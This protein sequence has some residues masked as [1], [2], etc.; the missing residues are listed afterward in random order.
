MWSGCARRRGDRHPVYQPRAL[1]RHVH[2]GSSGEWSPFFTF[3]VERNRVLV[4]I[5]NADW[6]LAVWTL[7]GFVAR[8]GRSGWRWARS[9][10]AGSAGGRFRA[11][12]GAMLSL[13]RHAPAALLDRYSRRRGWL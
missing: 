5:K 3:H 12:V 7:L 6:F 11:S 1:L 8:V 9:G 2:C 13:A 10:F 4:A